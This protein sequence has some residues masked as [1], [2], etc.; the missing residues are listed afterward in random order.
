VKPG[1][2]LPALQQKLSA[3]LRQSF[4]QTKTFF[5]AGE[6]KKLLSRAHVVLTPA[7]AGVQAGPNGGAQEQYGSKLYLLMTISSLVLLIA[8]ANIANL[9]LVRGMGRKAEMSLRTALGAMRGRI[10]QQLLTESIALSVL[11]GAVGLA[12]AY[13]GT[14]AL[15]MLAFPGA[16][17]LPIHA[18]PSPLVLGFAFGVSLLTGVLFGVAPAWIAART[19]PADALHSGSRRRRELLCCSAGWWWCRRRCRWCCW[20]ARDCLRRA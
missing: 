4:A 17:N 5:S 1:V 9:L 12:V 6:G 7:G 13:G 14:R 11:S 2:S 8:C 16:Q 18:N 15:L 20:W 10:I 19:E 3:L